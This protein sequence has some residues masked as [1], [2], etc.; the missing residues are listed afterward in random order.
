MADS[1]TPLAD[2]LLHPV[3][4]RILH[5]VMGRE[6]TTTQLKED[7]PEIPPAT[8][9]RH[10]AALIEGGYLVV[11]SERR[12]RGTTER[13]LALN[14]TAARIGDDEARTMT[15]TQH[16]QAFL[17]L[18][19]RLAEEFDRF[20]D[21]GELRD[22]MPQFNYNQVPLYVDDADVAA[23]GQGFLEVLQPYLEENPAKSRVILS[24][25][26]LPTA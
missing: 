11:V 6:V 4:W 13:T 3:R 22:R 25:I 12:V 9:Y 16:R 24:L 14:D 10:V 1:R 2:L 7:L 23:I 18:L 5:T 21:R 19:A 15:E 20:V 8:L 17:M 26:S